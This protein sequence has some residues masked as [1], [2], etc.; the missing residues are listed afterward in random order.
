MSEPVPEAAMHAHAMTLPP[1]CFT[2]EV[3]CFGSSAVPFFSTLLPSH[4]FDKG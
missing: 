3:A 1:P 4:H 2:D